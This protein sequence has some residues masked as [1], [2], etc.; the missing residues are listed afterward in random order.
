MTI[1]ITGSDWDTAVLRALAAD[2]PPPSG[3]ADRHRHAV[4]LLAG[5][6]GD[7]LRLFLRCHGATEAVAAVRTLAGTT[8]LILTTQLGHALMVPLLVE[9]ATG[10]RTLP[11][12]HDRNP[13]VRTMYEERLRL[14]EPLLLT[15]LGAGDI[16]RWLGS[17]AVIVA[18]LD[19]CYPGTRHTRDLPVLGGRLTVPTGLLALAARRNLETRAMAVPDVAGRIAPRVGPPLPAAVDA[20]VGAYGEWLDRCVSAAPEQWMAWGSLHHANA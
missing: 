5:T 11:I 6:I 12:V 13:L 10:R 20:A 4:R 17:D 8:R 16:R 7:D 1:R 15:R 14:G 19:T 18:N 3:D 9:E 2:P